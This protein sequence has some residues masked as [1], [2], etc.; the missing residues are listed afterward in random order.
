MG[1]LSVSKQEMASVSAMR[2]QH[3]L[4][5]HLK[6][7]DTDTAWHWPCDWW[8]STA[9]R[10]R[11][12]IHLAS[13]ELTHLSPSP[14]PST[15][16]TGYW[17]GEAATKRGV[18]TWGMFMDG[19]SSWR[20]WAEGGWRMILSTLTQ[21]RELSSKRLCEYRLLAVWVLC[22]VLHINVNFSL[23]L[24]VQ[25]TFATNMAWVF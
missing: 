14:M 15:R 16:R 21:Q 19:Q 6:N 20:Q 17:P 2:W 13:R 23:L 4:L 10:P 5:I 8:S 25:A 12:R 22:N 9:N 11:R 1:K 24:G 7:K 18:T 3:H